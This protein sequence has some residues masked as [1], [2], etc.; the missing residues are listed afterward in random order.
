MLFNYKGIDSSGKTIKAKIEATT[1]N[2]AKSKLK[3]KK[4]IYTDIKEDEFV[5]LKNFS[6]KQKQKINAL[7]LS[8][9]SRD[10]SIYLK[11]SIS[12]INAVKLIN[13]R[14]KNDKKLNSFFESIIS[15]LDEGKNLYTALDMQTSVILP[16]FYKQSIKI[17]EN[18]GILELVLLEL[19]IYLKEQDRIKKQISSAMA[20]P[21]FILFVSIMMVGFMLSFIVPKI[22]AIFEQYD[23]ALPPITEFVI[24]LGDFFS[25]NYQL[26][27]FGLVFGISLFIFLLKKSYKFKYFIDS[28]L[29]KIPF[30]SKLIEL[31][32]LSRFAYINSVLIRS[33]VPIVQ[34]FKLGANI[35]KN[36]VFKK[37]FEDAASK[38]VEGEKLSKILDNSKIYNV[39]IAFVQAV[40]IG[41]E[42]SE[43]SQILQNLAELYNESNK[44]KISIFLSLLEPIFMLIVG[45]IIGF[46]VVAMLLPIFSMN[47]G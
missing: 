18:G 34:S 8:T 11:S 38:V 10:L 33:G 43:L 42:T 3:A 47:F 2:E 13:S 5:F 17:S 37:L 24:K 27:F 40:A 15:L 36:L 35:L 12:L 32:E 45:S 21:L 1:L 30:L 16:E 39:D 7:E 9:I 19:S 6:F 31:G 4:I 46:I 29:L 26:L 22:T 20:Y 28:T 14:Y 23:Q 25:Q 44:D 41:E